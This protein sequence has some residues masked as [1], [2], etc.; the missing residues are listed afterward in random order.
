M[1]SSDLSATFSEPL[2]WRKAYPVAG[3]VRDSVAGSD[4]RPAF[5]ALYAAAVDGDE[6][7]ARQLAHLLISLRPSRPHADVEHALVLALRT[8]WA[9][10]AALVRAAVDYLLLDP[11]VA[12][13]GGGGDDFRQLSEAAA[14]LAANELF[15]TL[16]NTA[17]VGDLRLERL[18]I[19]LRDRAEVEP[20]TGPAEL[21]LAALLALQA[22]L[23]EY[24]WPE[25]R[26]ETAKASASDGAPA[27]PVVA[28]RALV[29]CIFRPPTPAEI[30]ALETIASEPAVRTLLERVRD[31]PAREDRYRQ[32][33]ERSS[34]SLATSVNYLSRDDSPFPRWIHAPRTARRVPM[35]V[36]A[37]M[38]NACF[39]RPEILVAGCGTGQSLLS[40]RATFPTAFITAVDCGTADLAY[41]KRKCE[42][43][44]VSGIEF[45]AA[46][47]FDLPPLGWM[48][49]LIEYAGAVR[50]LLDLE[51]ECAALARC[52]TPT[53][54][55]RLEV[56]SEGPRRLIAAL[57]GV[58][59]ERSLAPTLVDLR[60]F[61]GELI[62]GR[63]GPLPAALL[64]SIEFCTT[65]GLRN[66][67]FAADEHVLDASA[68]ITQLDAHG[69]DFVC[70]EA[71]E[72]LLRAAQAAG[73]A[74]AATWSI[75]DW[76]RFERA[77]PVVFGGRY[78]LWFARR[79][80]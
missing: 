23:V 70:G 76:E 51:D 73:F 40:L 55:L 30:A 18:L 3:E 21:R 38:R 31:E 34:L 28:G 1:G 68:W 32:Q 65:S 27:E 48:F 75:R 52:T 22:H 49:D 26:R 43:A 72:E 11:R 16:L 44:G 7:A 47:L 20:P 71:N 2:V 54:L 6:E 50:H 78:S 79:A 12:A 39:E 63:H 10:P 80:R 41:A 25:T 35:P 13:A 29:N 46:E 19:A 42:E 36:R 53:S 24:L 45:V 61:R 58:M 4:G 64:E 60:A 37:R 57:Q 67:L 5:D 69:F 33:L 17:V 77:D 14:Q 62:D 9:S 74:S 56:L 59:R 66:V 15:A 8:P